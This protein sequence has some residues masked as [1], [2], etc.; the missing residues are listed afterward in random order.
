MQSGSLLKR[1]PDLSAGDYAEFESI[2]S[3]LT[4]PGEGRLQ[5]GE[6]VRVNLEAKFREDPYDDVNWDQV[7]EAQMRARLDTIPNGFWATLRGSG[8][9]GTLCFDVLRLDA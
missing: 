8:L 5:P 1:L 7:E 2:W 4:A 6:A 9:A 3:R